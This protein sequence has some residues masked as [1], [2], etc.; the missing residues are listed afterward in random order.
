[1][2]YDMKAR[3]FY[4]LIAVVTVLVMTIGVAVA[5]MVVV[6]IVPV[7]V[8]RPV[9]FVIAIAVFTM[10]PPRGTPFTAA[11][12]RLHPTSRVPDIPSIIRSPISLH[13]NVAHLR[14]RRRRYLIPDRRRRCADHDAN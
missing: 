12:G 1:M 5:V 9:S 2:G 11:I 10:L 3:W 4:R 6:L 14:G 7:S 13:P 8:A